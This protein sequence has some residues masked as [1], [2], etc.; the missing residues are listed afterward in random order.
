[1]LIADISADD[2]QNTAYGLKAMVT[3]QQVLQANVEITNSTIVFGDS[4]RDQA[5]G[6]SPSGAS[7][8]TQP[9]QSITQQHS[10]IGLPT[11]SSSPIAAGLSVPP[12]YAGGWGSTNI[13]VPV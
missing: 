7:Q 9:S 4:A 10:A 11:D 1:M 6:S 8:G 13:N 2:T 3:F 12:T 5:T